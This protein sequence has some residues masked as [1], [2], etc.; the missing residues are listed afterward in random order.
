MKTW[1]SSIPFLLLVLLFLLSMVSPGMAQTKPIELSYSIFFPAPHKNTVL[2]GEWAKEI[3]KRTQG[4]VKITLFPGG[5]LTPADKCYDGV[6]KGISD[7]GMSVLGYTRGKFPLT[8]AIDLP[9]GYKNGLSATGLINQYYQKF[10]PKEF[11][12]VKVLYFHA[13]GPGI[14]HTKKPVMKL[15]EMKGLRIRSTGLSAKVVTALGGTPVAMPMGET[16]DALKRGMVDGSM[17]PIESLEGWKWGEV[18][19]ST[20]ESFGSAYST[21]F[22]VVMNK[23]KWNALSADVQKA[24]EAVNQEWIEKT[25]KIWDEIDKSGKAFTQKMGNQII[26]L[27]A[28]ENKRWGEAV[29]PILQDYVNAMKAKDLPGEEALK[30]CEENLKK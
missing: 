1:N 7:I 10:R 23:E 3:E 22:F 11:E 19:K 20:T 28:D 17:A 9:L 5:T 8:E 2:A 26:S 4:K 15:D 12:E 16:Y 18:V 29:K 14:L 6:V 27:S 25:G 24:I 13:H 21:G 30:F